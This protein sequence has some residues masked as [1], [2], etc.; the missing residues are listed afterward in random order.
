[1]VQLTAEEGHELFERC[2]NWGRWGQNDQLGTLNFISSEMRI[3]ASSSVHSGTVIAC[4]RPLATEPSA[5][6]LTPVIHHVTELASG[7]SWGGD[8][9]AMATHGLAISHLDALCHVHHE[10]QLY[11]GARSD[12]LTLHGAGQLGIENV[13]NKIIGRGVLLDV[14]AA[15]G[16]Y[17]LEPGDVVYPDDLEAA[18][19]AAGVSVG[20][21]DILLVRTGRWAWRQEHGPQSPLEVGLAGLHG[22]CLPWLHEREI[23]A[24]G[25]DGVQ[26]AI[27][28]NPV[29]FLAIHEIGLSAMG[30]YLLDNLDLEDLAKACASEER[31][32]FLLVVAPLV[33]EGGTA[34]PVN[35]L[36]LF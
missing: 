2:S 34:S 25:G 18:E 26:D 14:P 5:D 16:V 23:A 11:N 31:W 6:N 3:A 22:S 12:S 28:G 9:F 21:G 19:A 27:P 17:S 10:E 8:Y 7:E 24:L 30:L 1:V 15:R 35:P 29:G 32:H 20:T 13:K 36:A 33:L 4:G